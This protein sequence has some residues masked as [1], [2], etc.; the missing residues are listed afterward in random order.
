MQNVN[1]LSLN[2][3]QNNISYPT[4]IVMVNNVLAKIKDTLEG[5]GV[6]VFSLF[7]L[8]LPPQLELSDNSNSTLVDTHLNLNHYTGIVFR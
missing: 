4:D 2:I 7:A 8:P 3:R 6:H 1:T 5:E